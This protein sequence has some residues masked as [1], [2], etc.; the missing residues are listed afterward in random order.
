MNEQ[1]Q[2][3]LIQEFVSDVQHYLDSVDIKQNFIDATCI[4]PEE[5]EFIHHLDWGVAVYE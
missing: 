5:V 4:T 3:E 1:R 2:Q